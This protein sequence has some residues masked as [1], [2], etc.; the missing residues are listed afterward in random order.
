MRKKK[1]SVVTNQVESEMEDI[2]EEVDWGMIWT[3]PMT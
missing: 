2:N 1:Q 3:Y